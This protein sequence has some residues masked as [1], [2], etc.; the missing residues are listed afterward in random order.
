MGGA[1][2]ARGGQELTL[3][4][5]SLSEA[6]SSDQVFCSNKGIGDIKKRSHLFSNVSYDTDVRKDRYVSHQRTTYHSHQIFCHFSTINI[7]YYYR[8][9]CADILLLYIQVVV[10]L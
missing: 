2:H 6:R 8:A 9:G 3:P 5:T 10:L 7:I 1:G 4:K